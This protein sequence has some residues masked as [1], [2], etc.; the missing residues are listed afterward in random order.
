MNF[1]ILTVYLNNIIWILWRWVLKL[2]S[3]N[4]EKELLKYINFRGIEILVELFDGSVI[5]LNKN[6]TYQKGYIININ[7]K[8]L[9]ERIALKSIKKAEFFII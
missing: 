2:S 1:L 4:F 8:G 6:R 9:E 7:K 3:K 5:H